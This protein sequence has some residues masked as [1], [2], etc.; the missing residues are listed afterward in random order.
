MQ[1][2]KIVIPTMIVTSKVREL[3]REIA[4]EFK[5]SSDF[6]PELNE[7]IARLINEAIRRC[8]SNGRKTV[9]A[10]DL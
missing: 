6:V 7:K 8:D 1:N 5:V 4:P 3:L 10:G 2:G 9:R